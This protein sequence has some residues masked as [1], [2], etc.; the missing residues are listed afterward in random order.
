[1]RDNLTLWDEFV[2]MERLTQAGV[3]AA[4]HRDLL[5]RRGGYGAIGRASRGGTSPA[6]SASGSRS[7][8]RW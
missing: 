8:G 5:Q 7:P 2:P 1:M 4:I 6:A 3:E